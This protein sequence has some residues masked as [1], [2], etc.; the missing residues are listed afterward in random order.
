MSIEKFKWRAREYPV[1]A[2]STDRVQIDATRTRHDH[3]CT[4]SGDSTLE[5]SLAAAMAVIVPTMIV[6]VAIIIVVNPEAGSALYDVLCLRPDSLSAL[7]LRTPLPYCAFPSLLSAEEQC[8]LTEAADVVVFGC[9]MSDLRNS[10]SARQR[11][12]LAL[13]SSGKQTHWR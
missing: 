5:H 9:C 3:N 6:G 13:R 11:C 1:A 2:V 7:D 4:P 10:R 12:S 8:G